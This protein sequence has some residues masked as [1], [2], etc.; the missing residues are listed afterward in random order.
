MVFRLVNIISLS[1]KLLAFILNR[2]IVKR[3]RD[4]NIFRLIKEVF[5]YLLVSVDTIFQELNLVEK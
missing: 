4:W 1:Q 5:L 2:V 3:S